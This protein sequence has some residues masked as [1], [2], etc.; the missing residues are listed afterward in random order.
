M[1]SRDQLL[2]ND[3]DIII[4][5]Y[6]VVVLNVWPKGFIKASTWY[7]AV[8]GRCIS[9]SHWKF[10]APVTIETWF[11]VTKL[12]GLLSLLLEG[13]VASSS[14]QC[15]GHTSS[16]ALTFTSPSHFPNH[17]IITQLLVHCEPCLMR[18]YTL[19]CFLNHHICRFCSCNLDP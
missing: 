6:T 14:C 1:L 12:C 17:P 8:M 18:N 15:T 9:W 7:G 16:S 10:P 11:Q 5:Y 3:A 4:I 13:A 2:S 19:E